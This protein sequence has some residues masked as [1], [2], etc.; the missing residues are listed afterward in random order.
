MYFHWSHNATSANQLL[1]DTDT[2]HAMSCHSD[3]QRGYPDK[4]QESCNLLERRGGLWL[5]SNLL[6][7]H[8][9]VVAH[10]A[11]QRQESI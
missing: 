6:F 4:K 2:S 3:S 11:G 9:A 8:H 7:R 1:P 10:G 5:G